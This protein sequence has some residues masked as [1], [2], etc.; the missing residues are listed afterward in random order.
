M[1]MAAPGLGQT[2]YTFEEKLEV[3]LDANTP[4]SYSFVLQA[5]L[6]IYVHVS[7]KGGGISTN[8][9]LRQGIG[10]RGEAVDGSGWKFNQSEAK[11]TSKT[12][13]AGGDYTLKIENS[14]IAADVDVTITRLAGGG[15]AD[16][17]GRHRMMRASENTRGGGEGRARELYRPGSTQPWVVRRV[18]RRR[19]SFLRR[20]P[21]R[22]Q[23]PGL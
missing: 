23:L 6:R 2:P 7:A 11:L 20:I 16:Q 1:G 9:T 18:A 10:A 22:R 15:L 8:S 4:T 13:P 12:M 19:G 21:G 3:Q 14:R 5:G 17:C